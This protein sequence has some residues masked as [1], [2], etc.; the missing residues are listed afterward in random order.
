MAAS[1]KLGRRIKNPISSVNA[2]LSEEHSCQLNFHPDPICINGALGFFDEVAP[3]GRT[4]RRRRTT[5]S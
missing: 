2:Y 1:L 3:T 5:A 4:K